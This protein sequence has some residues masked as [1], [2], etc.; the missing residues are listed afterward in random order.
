MDDTELRAELA[1]LREEVQRLK[2]RDDAPPT[3]APVP[4]TALTRRGWFKAAAAAAVGGTALVLADSSPVAAANGDNLVI[5]NRGAGQVGTQ[6]ATS[7]TQLNFT[8]TEDIGFVVQ[9]GTSFSATSS[10]FDAAL[11]GWTNRPNHPHGVYGFSGSSTGSDS[12]GVLGRTQA[13]NSSGVLAVSTNSSSDGVRASAPSGGVAVRATAG[14][15]VR[16]DGSSVGVDASGS[17]AVLANGTSVGL[18]AT[19][20]SAVTADGTIYGVEARGTRAPI[21]V[22]PTGN[23]AAPDLTDTHAAGEI[24][25]NQVTGAI[26][27]ELWVCVE[28]GT[29]GVWRKLVAPATAGAL[30][31]I[32]P[33]RSY[34]SRSPSPFRARLAGPG[35]RTVSVADAR[36]LTTG[37]VTVADVVPVGATAVAFNLTITGTVGAGFPALAP[38]GATE[39]AASTIN[40]ATGGVTV[41]NAGIVKLGAD[42]DLVVFAG[43]A[44]ST[45]F[46]IDITGYYQ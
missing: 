23:T 36:D 13:A 9:S 10:S 31:P 29:P 43:G 30:H 1:A 21:F 14:T 28:A 39:F 2:E 46:I 42:R 35:N 3:P 12:A 5:G 38:G 27:G 40:W 24:R 22:P 8:G 4:D 6:T 45:D 32:D 41:A 44:G 15:A 7:P 26:D 16:A 37:T 25:S 11:A 19:G 33:V 34:D 18:A 20:A 17:S